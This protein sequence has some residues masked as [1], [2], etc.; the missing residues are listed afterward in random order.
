MNKI[1]TILVR[2]EK[3]TLALLGMG[4]FLLIRGLG[5]FLPQI[6]GPVG[7]L[8]IAIVLLVL[9]YRSAKNDLMSPSS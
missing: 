1:Y 6:N 7:M 9:G 8:I 3:K 2:F 5:E 4:L